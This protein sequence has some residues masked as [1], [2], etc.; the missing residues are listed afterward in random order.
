MAGV[1]F[2]VRSLHRDDGYTGL[3]KLYGAAGL[4]SSGWL[5]SRAFSTLVRD[6]F[7]LQRSSR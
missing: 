4:I 7:M 3:S 5:L 1:G 2:S 6:T